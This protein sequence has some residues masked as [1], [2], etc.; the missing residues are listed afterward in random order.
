MA[1]DISRTTRT[2]VTAIEVHHVPPLGRGFSDRQERDSSEAA[3]AL[4]SDRL[5]RHR[6]GTDPAIVGRSI[7]V[8]NVSLRITGVAPTGFTGTFPGLSIDLWIPLGAGNLVMHRAEPGR[9]A[10]LQ[11]LARL[12][13]GRFP[14]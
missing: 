12:R 13:G 4:I 5:W 1:P 7:T 11:V 3:V 14:C 6:F 10:T 9:V 8:N 2:R